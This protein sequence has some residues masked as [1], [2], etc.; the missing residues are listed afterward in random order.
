MRGV[1]AGLVPDLPCA[2]IPALL[3]LSPLAYAASKMWLVFAVRECD[4]SVE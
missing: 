4:Q 3:P 2:W 1:E